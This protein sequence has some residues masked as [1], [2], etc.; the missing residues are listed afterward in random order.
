MTY[1]GEDKI[2]TNLLRGIDTEEKDD[3]F[4]VN[5]SKWSGVRRQTTPRPD[6]AIQ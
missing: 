4:A 6:E 2:W 5:W 3:D 1:H